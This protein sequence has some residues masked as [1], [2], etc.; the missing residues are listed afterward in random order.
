MED[1]ENLRETLREGLDTYGFSVYEAENGKQAYE[2]FRELKPDII[3]LDFHLP[4]NDG[5]HLLP[6]FKV[7]ES[8]AAVIVMTGNPSP[9]IALKIT[10]LGADA[11]PAISDQPL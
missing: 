4:D 9:D 7:P 11:Y 8:Q 10:E 1:D 3:L 6:T 5:E 2:R